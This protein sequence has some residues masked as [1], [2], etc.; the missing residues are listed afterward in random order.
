MVS[1]LEHANSFV[2]PKTPRDGPSLWRQEDVEQREDAERQED[3]KRQEN[4]ERR[5][6]AGKQIDRP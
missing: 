3:A 1:I 4:A 5:D 2:A 6:A